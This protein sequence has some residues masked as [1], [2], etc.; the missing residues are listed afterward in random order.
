[1]KTITKIFRYIGYI[2][3]R[4]IWWLE[5]LV[6]RNKNIWVF[7]AWYGQK[8]SDNSKWLYEYV[9]NNNPEIK[10]VWITKNRDV[11]KKL[12]SQGKNVCLSSS[13]PG[14]WWCLRAKYVFL[15]STQDDVN[16]FFLNGAR[17]IWL[18]HGMP[19]KKIG[20][21]DDSK[22]RLP[23]WKRCLA[24]VIDPYLS[25]KPYATLTS[26]DFFTP[27]LERAFRLPKERIWNTGLPRC[28]AF[29]IDEKEHCIEC[30]R[31]EFPDA[32][33]LLYMPTFR[34]SSKMDGAIFSPFVK[35]FGFDQKNFISFLEQENIIFLFKPHFVDSGVQVEIDS[36]RFKYITDSDFEDLYVLLN[37]VDVLLTD[38]SSVYFDF[39]ATKKPIYLLPFDYNEYTKNSRGHYF[40]MYKEMSGAVCKNWQEF[41]KVGKNR[42]NINLEK[43]EKKFAEY[44]D[45]ESCKKIVEGINDL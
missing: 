37:S 10:A 9:L 17:Q 29:F 2:L 23:H 24:S 12:H 19:L 31:S 4:P 40:D 13:L 32:R 20:F 5:R 45:G 36:S 8:Y 27:F 25:L 26:S 21:D 3:F 38:Y 34:M 28:D 7:G 6:P 33:I 11:Y 35:E 22:S 18:W 44:L 30:L 1:M 39:L 16:K 15:S 43:D 14:V 42:K 41:Y